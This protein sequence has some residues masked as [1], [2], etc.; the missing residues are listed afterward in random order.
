ME[1]AYLRHPAALLCRT[2][3]WYCLRSV[4]IGRRLARTGPEKVGPLEY[5]AGWLAGLPQPALGVL[6]EAPP[7]AV[8]LE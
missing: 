3:R 7:L 8:A 1:A 6:E 5:P 2:T 4:W